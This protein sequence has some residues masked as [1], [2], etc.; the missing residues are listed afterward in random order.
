MAI[1]IR[2]TFAKSEPMRFTS[3][4]DLFRAWERT[5]RR[6][7][8]P[9]LFSQGFN[10]R[11]R[12]Q[13]AAALPLGFTSECEVIDAWLTDDSPQVSDIK[14]AL[15]QVQP[16]GIEIRDIVKIDP[17]SPPL[18]K[19][20]NS[21]EYLVTI[22]DQVPQLSANVEDILNKDVLPRQ[23]RGKSYDLRPLIEELSVSLPDE[24]ERQR[25]F[26]RL[27]AQEGKTGR[28]EEVLLTLDI[29]PES[30]R[31]HRLGLIFAD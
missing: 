29:P 22:L 13:L 30:T 1:R 14:S 19:L 7:G 28:P 20:I 3:H 18:Q 17:G 26:M 15:I 31:I 5:L 10:P 21:A 24:G 25:L 4:L 16:P 6:A 9:V 8:V 12:F 2:V 11:P 27:T 23:R